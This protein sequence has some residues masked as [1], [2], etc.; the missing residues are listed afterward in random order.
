[1]KTEVKTTEVKPSIIMLGLQIQKIYRKKR[2]KS[3]L[4]KIIQGGGPVLG[5]SPKEPTDI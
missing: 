1:L 2:S 3:Y 5:L 4:D